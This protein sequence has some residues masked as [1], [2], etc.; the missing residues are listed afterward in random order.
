LTFLGLQKNN[1]DT[2]GLRSILKLRHLRA[3]AL[4]ECMLIDALPGPSES[5][6][7]DHLSLNGTAV[8]DRDVETILKM[9]SLTQL[10]VAYT[11][12]TVAGLQRLCDLKG[13]R[14]LDISKSLIGD[15]VIVEM[16][17]KHPNIIITPKEKK[18]PTAPIAQDIAQDILD[19][20][21]TSEEKARIDKKKLRA[22]L[23]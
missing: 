18:Q 14:K 21:N 15:P 8:S 20:S 19:F 22:P 1:L 6:E 2:R 10:E 7:L 3:L 9:K 5:P 17:K 16:R 13:L 23:R 4:S 12:I 11:K